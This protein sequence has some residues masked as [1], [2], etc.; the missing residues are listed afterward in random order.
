MW[1][2][3]EVGDS[4]TS[5]LL[6]SYLIRDF[7]KTVFHRVLFF[8]ISLLGKCEKRALKFAI[9][10]FVTLPYFSKC[11]HFWCL[12]KICTNLK[13]KIKMIARF[14]TTQLCEMFSD[15]CHFTTED[16][17]SN[18][19]VDRLIIFWYMYCIFCWYYI[20]NFLQG[21]KFRRSSILLRWAPAICW[22]D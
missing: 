11:V 22:P 2:H 5:A 18:L 12:H 1:T 14:S 6:Y 3:W 8:V 13:I 20:L 16:T 4:L 7:G 10:T 19:S 15:E 21:I 9:Q 17:K